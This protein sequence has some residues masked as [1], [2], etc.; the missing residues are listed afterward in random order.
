M[1]RM[2]TRWFKIKVNG[3]LFDV[4]VEEVAGATTGMPGRKGASAG[5]VHQKDVALAKN[6]VNQA[7]SGSGASGS[8]LAKAPMAGRIV[9]V[10][11]KIGDR[12]AI[13]DVLVVLEAMKMEIE[14]RSAFAGGVA[15]IFVRPNDQI[16]SGAPLVKM[17]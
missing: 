13:G 9:G 10:S 4:E 1:N 17:G 5:V 11:V 3:N 12:V 14:V 6:R 8:E 16:E 7:K 2:A 15:E